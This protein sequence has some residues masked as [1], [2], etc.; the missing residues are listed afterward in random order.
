MTDEQRIEEIKARANRALLPASASPDAHDWLK[1]L[2]SL[3]ADDIP[4]LLGVIESQR[5]NPR[6]VAIL[7]A[8]DAYRDADRAYHAA[9]RKNIYADHIHILGAARRANKELGDAALSAEGEQG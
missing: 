1:S 9:V 5:L 7:A 3:L 6:Q 8:A 2:N 4:Y